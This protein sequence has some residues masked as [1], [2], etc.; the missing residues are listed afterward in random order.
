MKWVDY[1]SP[2]AL[3]C[4]TISSELQSHLTIF[5][6]ALV[7]AELCGKY[8][9]LANQTAFLRMVFDESDE[10]LL[11]NLALCGSVHLIPV[12]SSEYEPSEYH[13]CGDIFAS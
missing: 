3:W 4:V 8:T 5:L 11:H 1:L 9:T 10:S 7:D 13:I 6:R 2:F 12:E